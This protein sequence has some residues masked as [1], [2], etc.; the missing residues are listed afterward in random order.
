MTTKLDN[1]TIIV[2]GATGNLGP[3]MTDKLLNEGS[4]VIGT[5]RSEEQK[6]N[7]KQHAQKPEEVDYQKIDLLETQELQELKD[8]IENE[9]G[10]IDAI[11][12]LVGGFTLGALEDTDKEQFETSLKAH[13][14]TVFLTV[15]TFAEHLENNKG[16]I[17]NFSQ[18]KALN[19]KPGAVSYTV[20]KGALTTLTETLNEELDNTRVN[21]IAPG[22]IDVPGNREA[23][24]DADFDEWI[25]REEIID[26]VEYFLTNNSVEGE[27]V[28][29]V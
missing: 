23:M 14:T 25:D 10:E 20:G 18:L 7:A 26:T 5:Y 29:N 27:V 2:T 12:N 8:Y 9:Y 13:A 19:P 15:K 3:F 11:V 6:N 4:N 24:P 1:K 22:T 17:V 21:A 28:K 16:S